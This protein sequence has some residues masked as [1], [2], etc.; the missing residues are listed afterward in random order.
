[1]EEIKLNDIADEL[2]IINK[3]TIERLFQEENK[4]T[5]VL[6]MFYYK[7]AKWQKHNPIKANDEYVKKSLHWG[8]DKVRNLKKRLKEMELI[9]IEKRVNEKQQIEG[10][11]VKLKYY[12]S[13]I[14]S[15]TTPSLPLVASQEVNTINN[16]ILNT[17]N[18]KN[19]K[20]IY[21]ESW[22]CEEFVKNFTEAIVDYL[23][24]RT[25][26]Q[27]KTNNLKTISLVRARLKEGF[28]QIDF[29][30]VVDTKC[31]EWL[32]TEMEKYLRPETL[33]GTKFDNY[34]NQREWK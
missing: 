24:E 13:T 9:E 25:G 22:D 27:Y 8:T 20:E 33:F 12:N 16:N 23:N 21:K 32:D 14:P 19:K 4:D 28:K 2:L 7:T 6:Y 18:N 11:Y 31:D 5:L 1:M 17:N 29:I 30:R 10:W 15:S 3:T 26:R 34:L